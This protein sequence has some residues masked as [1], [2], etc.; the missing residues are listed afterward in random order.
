MWHRNI[1]ET[2]GHTP[3]VQLNKLAKNV[4]APV[5]IKLESFNPGGSV[6]DRIGHAMIQAAEESGQLK[7]GGILVEA[8]SGNTGTGIVQ[9]ARIKGYRCIFTVTEKV[10]RE[11]QDLLTAFGAELVLCPLDVPPEDPRSYYSVAQKIAMETPGAIYLNQYYNEANVQAH[12]SS[13]GPEIWQQTEGRITHFFATASTGGTISGSARYL[14]EKNKNIQVIGVD[15]CGSSYHKYFHEGVIDSDEVY[16]HQI[17]GAGK[18]YLAG[19]M[20]MELLNDY[21][22]TSD[23]E[24]MRMARRLAKEEGVFAGQSS[25]LALAGALEWLEQRGQEISQDSLV[26]VLLPDSGMKYISKTFNDDWLKEKDLF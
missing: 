6:K 12:Y 2:I 23:R 5:L 19:N 8:T 17:E 24:A 9:A 13:T 22:R 1:V 4:P 26:V 14:K 10:S 18:E 21:T 11:K 7:P 3:L 15:P 25:G 20:H 16:S